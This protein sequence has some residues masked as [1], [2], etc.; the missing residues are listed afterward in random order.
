ASY[1]AQVVG[2]QADATRL[3][4][5]D[6]AVSEGDR[7]TLGALEAEIF[8]VY[9]HTIGHIAYYVAGAEACFTADS[10]MALG[11]GRLFEGT[12][13]QMWDSMQKMMALPALILLFTA[14]AAHLNRRRELRRDGLA[15]RVEARLAKATPGD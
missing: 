12:P 9:G 3:P 4:D 6:L 5:L 8:D 15:G 13:A 7:L 10:L 14:V 11:C 2:A 1:P